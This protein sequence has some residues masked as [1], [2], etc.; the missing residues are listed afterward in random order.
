MARWTNDHS[1]KYNPW[2]GW[3][4]VDPK[5]NGR[6]GRR[7][8]ASTQASPEAAEAN[9]RLRAT[10][11]SA[12]V[13]CSRLPGVRVSVNWGMCGDCASHAICEL[14]RSP[15]VPSETTHGVLCSGCLQRGLAVEREYLRR[16]AGGTPS[17][18]SSARRYVESILTPACCPIRDELAKHN[19]EPR[20]VV[21]EQLIEYHSKSRARGVICAYCADYFRPRAL[22][23]H[24]SSAHAERWDEWSRSAVADYLLP[25]TASARWIR[26]GTCDAVASSLIE[27]TEHGRFHIPDVGDAPEPS[28][29]H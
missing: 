28:H 4:E 17:D 22:P 20:S 21:I 15:F 3:R 5:R 6:K 9:R 23:S 2:G 13:C 10:L 25:D 27:I 12:C 16:V 29:P 1:N 18:L 14:C 11:R 8:G 24:V 26:C 7:E 19:I